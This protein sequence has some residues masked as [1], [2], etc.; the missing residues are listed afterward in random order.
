MTCRW[1]SGKA[2]WR[3][4]YRERRSLM[5]LPSQQPRVWSPRNVDSAC[6]DTGYLLIFGRIARTNSYVGSSEGARRNLSHAHR[7]EKGRNRRLIWGPSG[8][9]YL[10]NWATARFSSNCSMGEA[11][12]R[13]IHTL[14]A[15]AHSSCLHRPGQNGLPPMLSCLTREQHALRA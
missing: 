14:L 12:P 3:T 5:A 1:E 9:T 13:K 7:L 8:R 11:V 10:P 4:W 6:V 15:L 2:G